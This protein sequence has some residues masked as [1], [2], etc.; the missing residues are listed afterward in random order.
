MKVLDLQCT[1]QH[2]FEGWFASEDD[3]VQQLHKGMLACPMCG[4]T[5]VHKTLSAPRLNLKTSRQ[6]SSVPAAA[7]PVAKPN[8]SAPTSNALSVPPALQAQW[9]KAMRAIVAQTEDVGER[10]ADEVRA[11]HHGDADER[12]IRGKTTPDVAMELLEEGIDIL[13]L[14]SLDA[15]KETLQ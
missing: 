13:P 4:S 15:V 5:D 9:L 6:D 14:P 12:A 10:F 3:Y 8:E 2:S 11:M 1:H 7:A